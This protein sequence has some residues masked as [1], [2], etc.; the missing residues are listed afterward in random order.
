M[1]FADKE[2]SEDPVKPNP[3]KGQSTGQSKL[4]QILLQQPNM[5]ST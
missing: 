2:A 3:Y 4:L 5:V 1:S